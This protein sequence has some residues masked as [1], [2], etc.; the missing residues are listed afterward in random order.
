MKTKV[1]SFSFL[2]E[3]IIVILFF[4]FGA[5][6]CAAFIV[7]A[8]NKQVQATALQDDLLVAQSMIETMQAYPDKLVDELFTVKQVDQNTYQ[9]GNLEIIYTNDH[10]EGKVV[11]K[12]NEQV[13]S[14]LPFVLGGKANE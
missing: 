6:V 12:S 9:S 5:T 8:K 10:L 13:I 1:H 7:E 11:I 4:A 14:E 2:M 3:L